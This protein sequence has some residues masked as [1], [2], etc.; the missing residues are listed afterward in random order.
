M[1]GLCGCPICGNDMN[2][3]RDMCYSCSTQKQIDEYDF[4]GW[5]FCPSCGSGCVTQNDW[6]KPIYICDIC[7]KEFKD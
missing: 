3:G 6:K 5:V 7:H 2:C 1:D 4:E